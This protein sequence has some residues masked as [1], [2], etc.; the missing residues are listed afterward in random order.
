[1]TLSAA[2]PDLAELNRM[3]ARY[4]PAEL[5]V[6]TSK[7]SKG[8]QQALKKLL[9]AAKV[10]DDIFLN[11]RWQY[12]SVLRS[13]LL[14]D[15]SALGK[16]RLHYFDLN[17]GPWSELDEQ[18][19]FLRTWR[20]KLT[21]AKGGDF[22]IEVPPTKPLGAGFYPEDLT[23]DEFETWAAKLPKDQQETA[24]GFFSLIRRGPDHKI[25]IVPY[26]KAYAV[27]LNHAATLLGQAAAL[28][29]NAT[30]K[31]FL[32]L[33]AKAFLIDNYYASDVAWMK[34]DAPIDVTIGPYETYNDELFGYK[35][36]FE[37][38][39][40]TL[41]DEAE[42]AKMKK[43]RRSHSGDRKHSSRWNVQNAQASEARG[44]CSDPRRE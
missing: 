40:Y 1:M 10:I 21:Y 7:L 37:A 23:K 27:D 2:V 43:L 12:N 19:A 29:S 3:I 14:K 6:D 15:Q 8:D 33:R 13:E 18:K 5:K 36:A 11:Q 35:A 22:I 16:A 42:T 31:D 38:Y 4:A 9:E 32:N 25:T 39:R 17:K 28:T 26:S 44:A 30:L 24:R 34:L 41:R 20:L